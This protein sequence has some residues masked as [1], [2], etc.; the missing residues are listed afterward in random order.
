MCLRAPRREQIVD[1]R[2]PIA[3]VASQLLFAIWL[4]TVCI[5]QLFAADSNAETRSP[6]PPA[7]AT[8]NTVQTLHG[9][10][11]REP[12][13]WLESSSSSQV[14]AWIEAQN[15]FTDKMLRSTPD[16]E[17]FNQRVR[18]LA[19][20][21]AH[22]S[23][24]TL[25]GHTLFY[26]QR[27]PPQAKPVL[28]AQ[29]WPNGTRRT[30]FDP[31]Q[32]K[33]NVAISGYWP[34]PHGRYVAYA[35]SNDARNTTDI[36]IVSVEGDTQLKDEITRVATLD[37]PTLAW[38]HDAKGFSYVGAATNTRKQSS[39]FD[40]AVYHHE[41]GSNSERDVLSFSQGYTPLIDLSVP[42]AEYELLPSPASTQAALLSRIGESSPAQVFLRDQGKWKPILDQD[43]QVRTGAWIGDR[44]FVIATGHAPHGRLLAAAADGSVTEIVPQGKRVMTSVAPIAGGFLLTREYGPDWRVEHY[45]RNGKLIRTL[46]LP[47]TGIGIDGI[48]SNANTYE[49]L[50]AYSGWTQAPRWVAYDGRTGKLTTIFEVTP[51]T[52]YSKIQTH[53][54]DAISRD[55][56]RVPVTILS[57]AGAVPDGKAPTI[58]YA[59]GAYGISSR[60][61]FLASRLAWIERGGIF[62]VANIR[63]GGELGENWHRDGMLLNKQ[64]G[65]DDF[66]AAAR[67]LVTAH[68][69][70]PD[71][72][73][74]ESE[75]AGG[76]IIGAALTQHPEQYAAAYVEGGIFDLLRN[77]TYPNGRYNTSEFG[78]IRDA[79]QFRSMLGYSPL[80]HVRKGTAYPAVL[81]LVGADDQIV[82]A[83][84]SRKFTAALQAATTSKR[85]I[86]MLTRF[87][88]GHGNEVSFSQRVRNESI[89]LGFFATQLGLQI[90]TTPYSQESTQEATDH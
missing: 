35:V 79:E 55:S 3:I 53:R 17:I 18:E 81:L 63:G 25:I 10:A 15:A 12:Y 28:I 41:L 29:R 61:Y 27:V 40:A 1:T 62:A 68:W 58:L 83:W 78:S 74:I 7:T 34:S 90:P 72:L 11:V 57:L 66:Y 31:N 44:L 73:G 14:H 69:T 6:K 39:P 5:T 33:G 77:E 37:V 88:A 54:L 22:R 13:R 85:P 59:Y 65:V 47:A 75:S 4:A 80:Q 67:A 9:I 71:R 36:R 86:L 38:D 42:T 43:A 24:P 89:E 48:A 21:S 32:A 19:L 30:L 60:P 56:A 45:N 23:P 16:V 26:I 46:A 84:Q 20:T 2:P 87:G 50:I 64:N 49:A 82:A 52:D 76:I 70:R 8:D 51:T